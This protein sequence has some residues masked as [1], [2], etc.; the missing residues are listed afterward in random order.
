VSPMNLSVTGAGPT[1][2]NGSVGV[3]LWIEP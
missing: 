3:Y 1:L 2:A